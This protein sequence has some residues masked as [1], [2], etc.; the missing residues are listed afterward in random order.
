MTTLRGKSALVTGASRGIGRATTLALAAAG[1][2][3][4]VHYG[5][6]EQEANEVVAGIRAL[7]GS[8]DAVSADL[9]SPNGA[10]LRCSPRKY[11]LSLETIWM[12]LCSTPVSARQRPLQIT[13]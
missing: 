12:C 6:S 8:A 5:R 10:A 7:D 1:A 3:V 11:A 13:Q 2:H 9:G 4:L